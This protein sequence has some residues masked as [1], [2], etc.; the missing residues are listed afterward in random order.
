MNVETSAQE[1]AEFDF[2]HLQPGILSLHGMDLHLHRP[3]CLILFYY[4]II[5]FIMLNTL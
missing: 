4:L 5:I 2:L 3:N 1:L